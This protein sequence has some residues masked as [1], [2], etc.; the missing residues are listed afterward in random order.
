MDRYTDF[1]VNEISLTGQ[2]LHLEDIAQSR[3]KTEKVGVVS[4]TTI[5][6]EPAD[7][8]PE[9]AESKNVAAG[10]NQRAAALEPEVV[11]VRKPLC[12]LYN[13]AKSA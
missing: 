10:S 5:P 4:S 12:R 13:L 8:N 9:N 2:V 1:L 11:E 6:A 7:Q 3:Q